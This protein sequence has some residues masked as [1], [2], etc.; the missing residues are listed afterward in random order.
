MQILINWNHKVCIKTDYAIDH[1]NPQ[2]EKL[3]SIC[4]KPRNKFYGP[5]MKQGY[6]STIQW[7]T[8]QE[9]FQSPP[10]IEYIH[11][12]SH[13]INF[14]KSCLQKMAKTIF[15]GC[16]WIWTWFGEIV[17]QARRPQFRSPEPM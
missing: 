1:R 9:K 13:N 15:K 6:F 5:G 8:S 17:E 2:K 12:D 4:L 10:K 14:M 7:E 16:L 11:K 3:P